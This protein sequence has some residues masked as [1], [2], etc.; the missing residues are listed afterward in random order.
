MFWDNWFVMAMIVP[1]LTALVNVLDIHFVSNTYTDE[2]DG[3]VISGFFQSLPWLLVPFGFISFHFPGLWISSLA[4]SSGGCLAIA[5]YFY[6][7]ALFHT[8][9][10]VSVQVLSN[11][12]ILL[13]P[14]LAWLWIGEELVLVHY[15]GIFLAFLGAL[16]L[17]FSKQEVSGGFKKFSMIMLGSITALSISMVLQEEAYRSV[18]GD[19]WTVFLLFVLGSTSTSFLLLIFDNKK[20]FDRMKHISILSR[21]NFLVFL[22]AESLALFGVLA[23]QRSIDLSP[24][25]S[26]VAAITEGLSPVFVLLIS[27]ALVVLFWLSNKKKALNIYQQQFSSLWIKALASLVV[28]FGIY[29]IS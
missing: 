28:I 14:F 6:F 16:I 3:M 21:K 8:T 5:F 1:F 9:D 4:L 26:L 29:M 11:L 25:V 10:M 23:L 24:E 12:S 15:A 7:K 19:F 22:L 18:P 20:F 2:W 17:S 27:G 13:V